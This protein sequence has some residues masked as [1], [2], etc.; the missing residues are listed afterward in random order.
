MTAHDA[1]GRPHS[2]DR[3][4]DGVTTNALYSLHVLLLLLLLL[5]LLSCCLQRCNFVVAAVRIGRGS[6][7][8]PCF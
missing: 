8:F 6:T 3:L 7:Q 5:L 4:T 1:N 2:T